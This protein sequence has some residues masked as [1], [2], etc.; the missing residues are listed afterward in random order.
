MNGLNEQS[1]EDFR[2]ICSSPQIRKVP[3]F[4]F[5]WKIVLLSTV[6][7]TNFSLLKWKILLLY[8]NGRND[9]FTEIIL[10]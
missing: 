7:K 1:R 2:I 3:E 9:F 10:N 8:K 4:R 6:F 5:K